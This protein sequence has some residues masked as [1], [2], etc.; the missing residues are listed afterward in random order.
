M[1]NASWV[2]GSVRV[3]VAI[4]IFAAICL[5]MSSTKPSW[6]G[7]KAGADEQK[8]NGVAAAEKKYSTNHYSGSEKTDSVYFVDHTA[9]SNLLII[10]PH[11][12]NHHRAGHPKKADM[13]TGGIAEKVAEKTGASVLTTTGEVSDWGDRWANRD[14]QFT[15]ILCSIPANVK[16]I[17]LHGMDDSHDA[18]ASI[19]TGPQ[20]NQETLDWAN[21]INASLGNGSKENGAKFAATSGCTDTSYM[22]KRGHVALQL[23]LSK[24]ERRSDS[25]VDDVAKAITQ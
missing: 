21:K 10:A 20:P 3:I 23:E 24:S 12:T 4:A 15:Q 9:T 8:G 16:V 13:Y 17:D 5:F 2:R 1:N 14:D 7:L 19:G 25:V 18:K 22:Q 11:A 6:L